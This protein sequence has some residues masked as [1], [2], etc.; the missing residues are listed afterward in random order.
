MV[1][2]DTEEIVFR[3]TIA[4]MPEK[5]YKEFSYNWEIVRAR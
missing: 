4:R 2:G 1:E 3:E 5:L